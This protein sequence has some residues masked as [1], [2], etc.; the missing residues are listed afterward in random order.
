MA[1]VY[2]IDLDPFNDGSLLQSFLFE[3]KWENEQGTDVFSSN[4]YDPL[5]FT[6]GGPLHTFARSYG[7]NRSAQMISSSHGISG[8]IDCSFTFLTKRVD[9]ASTQSYVIYGDDDQRYNVKFLINHNGYVYFYL[10]KDGEYVG[11]GAMPVANG[12]WFSVQYTYESATSTNRFYLNGNLVNTYVFTMKHN[13]KGI[14][15]SSATTFN[16]N[17]YLNI[18][19]DQVCVWSKKLSPAECIDVANT[20]I[21]IAQRDQTINAATFALSNT[22]IEPEIRSQEISY[23]DSSIVSTSLINIGVLLVNTQYGNVN[24]SSNSFTN[25]TALIGQE[26]R[27]TSNL[28][29]TSK[30]FLHTTVLYRRYPLYKANVLL[31]S[32]SLIDTTIPKIA[33]ILSSSILSGRAGEVIKG[34]ALL[35]STSNIIVFNEI[36]GSA[37]LVSSSNTAFASLVETLASSSIVSNSNLFAEGIVPEVGE[38]IGQKLTFLE[39]QLDQLEATMPLSTEFIKLEDIKSFFKRLRYV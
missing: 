2:D 38:T 1:N 5:Y 28:I 16:W 17:D 18:N 33:S 15:L 11:D 3:D 34:K 19:V 37:T 6:T 9:G 25:G 13:N 22:I 14:L 23:N 30:V 32:T 12:Q 36:G 35:I 39:N 10:H 29:S 27:G 7:Q 21:Y 8:D 31:N 20:S 26:V 24:I 4:G